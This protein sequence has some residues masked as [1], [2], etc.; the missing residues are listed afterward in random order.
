[1]VLVVSYLSCYC[2]MRGDAV[3]KVPKKIRKRALMS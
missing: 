3:N 1:V 2:L